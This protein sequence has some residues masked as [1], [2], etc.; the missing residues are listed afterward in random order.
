MARPR[1]VPGLD[2]DERFELAAARV[3]EVRAAELFAHAD[4]V[5]GIEDIEP[6]H[7][8]RVAARRLRSGLE[9]FRPCF[10]KKRY[11]AAIEPLKALADALGERRDRDVAIVFLEGFEAE[12][13]AGDRGRLEI[14]VARLRDEQAEANRALRPHVGDRSLAALRER[15]DDLTAAAGR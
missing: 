2:C 4:G 9:L 3:I 10:P 14:L 12:A 1:D 8:M 13:P 5:L 11:R 7:D 15:F 6:L